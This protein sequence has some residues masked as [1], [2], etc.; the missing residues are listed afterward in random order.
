MSLK[1]RSISVTP[2]PPPTTTLCAIAAIKVRYTPEVS[3]LFRGIT[4]AKDACQWTVPCTRHEKLGRV[5]QMPLIQEA[6]SIRFHNLHR[7]STRRASIV[8][9]AAREAVFVAQQAV[10][11]TTLQCLSSNKTSWRY[12]TMALHHTALSPSI[13]KPCVFTL[14]LSPYA[15]NTFA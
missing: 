14:L 12:C 10:Q 5:A 3:H 7:D 2:P 4:I 15:S 13:S 11:T 9:C 8:D 6:L 1:R